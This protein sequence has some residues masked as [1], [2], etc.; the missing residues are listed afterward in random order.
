MDEKIC[1][2]GEKI[3]ENLSMISDLIPSSS[4]FNDIFQT[5][6]I[7]FFYFNYC[8]DYRQTVVTV[9]QETYLQKVII[10]IH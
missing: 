9:I 5:R 2:R 10:I 7:F 8:I 1:R 6:Y 4:D 3:E